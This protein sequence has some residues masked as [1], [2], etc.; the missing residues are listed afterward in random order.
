MQN[1]LGEV[2][3][4]DAQIVIQDEGCRQT[5]KSASF[6]AIACRSPRKARARKQRGA[7]LG[8]GKLSDLAHKAFER[9][10]L[11]IDFP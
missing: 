11:L 7:I 6:A 2:A 1:L 8:R 10:A 4:G 9:A 3:G 5:R